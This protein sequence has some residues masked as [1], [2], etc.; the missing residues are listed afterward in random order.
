ME[1]ERREKE[2]ETHIYQCML[3]SLMMEKGKNGARKCEHGGGRGG[4]GEC[5]FACLL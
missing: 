3:L 5:P 4:A 1:P 2:R